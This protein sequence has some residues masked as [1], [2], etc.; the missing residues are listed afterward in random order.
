FEAEARVAHAHLQAAIVRGEGAFLRDDRVSWSIIEAL[1]RVAEEIEF[2]E[3]VERELELAE[4]RGQWRLLARMRGCLC[5]FG[6][7]RR[8][9]QWRGLRFRL[10]RLLRLC[11]RRLGLRF[12]GRLRQ[13][14]AREEC[15]EKREPEGPCIHASLHRHVKSDC[16]GTYVAI[17]QK[18]N[19]L[20]ER[21]VGEISVGKAVAARAST[22]L[23]KT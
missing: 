13:R 14:P 2:D 8:C 15:Q 7:R 18:N 22:T 6:Q 16:L 23:R 12:G 9:R 1:R 21:S 20:D 17:S 3:T 19:Q 11:R 5:G 4:H 10:R